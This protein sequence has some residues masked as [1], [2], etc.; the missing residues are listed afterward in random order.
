MAGY[1]P[2]RQQA[3]AARWGMLDGQSGKRLL[4]LFDRVTRHGQS[5]KP[6]RALVIAAVGFALLAVIV[7]VGLYS[8][9]DTPLP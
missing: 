7:M 3:C 6:M 5:G 1:F 8:Y 4:E 9:T 2:A